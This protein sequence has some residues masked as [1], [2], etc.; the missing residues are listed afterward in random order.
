MNRRKFFRNG[1]L[2]AIGATVLNPFEGNAHGLDFDTL[3]KN[4]K[5]K[6]TEYEKSYLFFYAIFQKKV[7]EKSQKKLDK[8]VEFCGEALRNRKNLRR[9]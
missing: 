6:G 4:K 7:Q 2:F 3:K 9:L 5:A 8:Q 1:S